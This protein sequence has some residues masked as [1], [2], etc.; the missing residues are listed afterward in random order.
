VGEQVSGQR[1]GPLH[2][3]THLKISR[4]QSTHGP[5]KV[6]APPRLPDAAYEEI[7]DALVAQAARMPSLESSPGKR[8]GIEGAKANAPRSNVKARPPADRRLAR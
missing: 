1:S 4:D 7:A 5:S 3:R 2:R 8:H 6:G